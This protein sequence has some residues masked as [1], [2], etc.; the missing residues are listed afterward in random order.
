[1]FDSLASAGDDGQRA[2]K[3]ILLV[4]FEKRMDVYSIGRSKPTHIGCLEGLRGTVLGAKILPAP[5]RHDPLRSFRPLVAVVINSIYEPPKP[6]A[7]HRPGTSHS[8]DSEFDTSGSMLQALYATDPSTTGRP[9][10]FQTT[11]EVYSLRANKNLATLL[12]SSNV[13]AESSQDYQFSSSNPQGAGFTVQASS[14]FI[15]IGSG[16]SGEVFV[17]DVGS[18]GSDDVPAAFKCLGKVWTR[19]SQER[20]RSL[21]VSSDSS[22]PEKP[23]S[24]SPQRSDRLGTPI[25]D[26]SHRWLAVVPP[27][28]SSQKT[29]RAIVTG[30]RS[31]QKVPG[32]TSHTAPSE[33]AITCELD[34]PEAE[35]L[36]NKVARDVTQE[37]MKGARWVGGQ[38]IQAWNNYW[39]KPPD[40]NNGTSP[41]S[42]S[43]R[44]SSMP[45]GQ[46]SFPPTHANDLLSSRKRSQPIS[47]SLLD[48]EKLMDGQRLK[49]DKALQPVAT[50]SVTN[51]C[52]FVSFAPSGLHI[53]TAS[54]KG[55]VQQVWSLL[56]MVH[57][58]AAHGTDRNAEGR[59]PFVREVKRFTRLTEA[60]IV[61]VVWAHPRGEKLAIITDR[62][63]VHI[64]DIPTMAFQWPPP[65]RILK[66]NTPDANTTKP[67][68]SESMPDTTIRSEQAESRFGAA[69]NMVTGR[70]QPL[71]AAVRGRPVS[72]GS[73]LAGWRGLTLPAGAGATGSKAVSAGFNKSIGAATGTV[74]SLRH[75][76]ENRLSLPASFTPVAPRCVMWLG[77]R[78]QGFIAA[79]GGE[80]IKI[81][82][83]TK[84]T[85][86]KAGR[87]RSSVFASRP[88]QFSIAIPT[89]ASRKPYVGSRGAFE[90]EQ[91]ALSASPNRL[92]QPLPQSHQQKSR[93]RAPHPL[94]C[95]EIETNAPYQP[96]HTD[97]RVAFSLHHD[98]DDGDTS[99][100][101]DSS[102]LWVFGES[103]PATK[104]S[105]CPHTTDDDARA[106]Q[107]QATP[108]ENLISLEG[109]EEEGQQF[110]VTTRRKRTKE[111]ATSEG[112][113]ES[114]FFEYG[115]EM[116]DFAEDRV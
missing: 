21:S 90:N 2:I 98:D 67:S 42:Y 57:G 52:S 72:T 89:N 25:F 78:N 70:T 96:F 8:H 68:P 80:V 5:S 83:V 24:K 76:G 55:D 1:M 14:K 84:S 93:S 62:G 81:H 43:V 69:F 31:P 101:Q 71:F 11:V 102:S 50:F 15:V 107:S 3:D 46:P 95:A 10:Q 99:E 27:S 63:T 23:S 108:L 88:V 13:N 33:P 35:S 47:V 32:L 4:G 29:I 12:R 111:R 116:V 36:F 28:A 48:L 77:G 18:G 26:L 34:T 79:V 64:H 73:T 65:R 113:E 44:P 40:R 56:R 30:N 7:D 22:D 45:Q 97:R 86:P 91:P 110:V 74:H 9:I 17:F 92:W 112:V 41:N 20:S 16:M 61:D 85:N 87:R 58:E 104:V 59:G 51:G 114:D 49:P 115:C 37:L 105:M 66:S 94:S 60:S 106:A 6:E 54:T 39:S 109:N 19:T 75:L 100:S 38:G 103:I 53:L 82:S